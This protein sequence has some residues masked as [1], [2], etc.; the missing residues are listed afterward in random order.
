MS[1]AQGHVLLALSAQT[2]DRVLACLAG[3]DTVWA[4]TFAEVRAAMDRRHFDLIVIGTH[5]EES[6]TFDI[7][8]HARERDPEARLVCVRGRPF[9]PALGRSTMRA[10]EAASEVLGA[11]LVIDLFDYPDDEDGNRAIGALFERQLLAA[12]PPAA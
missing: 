10:F 3:C 11:A 9:P 7:L 2:R 8:R 12:S 4:Q 1:P 6:S 5:F